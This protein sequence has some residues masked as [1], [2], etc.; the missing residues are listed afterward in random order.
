MSGSFISSSYV[1]GTT[2]AC[3]DGT[4]IYR[5]RMP[6]DT[7]AAPSPITIVRNP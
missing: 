7:L 5:F 3:G 6:D 4:S 2:T 1:T